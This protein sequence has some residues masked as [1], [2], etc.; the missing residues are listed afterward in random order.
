MTERSPEELIVRIYPGENGSFTLY[1]DDGIS[2]EY[3]NGAYLKTNLAYEE[4]NGVIRIRI[5]PSGK[6]YAGMPK[7]R[8][9]R[10]EL[11]LT[12]RTLSVSEDGEK[13]EISLENGMNIVQTEKMKTDRP[14]TLILK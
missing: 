6:G 9:Y 2:E 7:A 3:Q 11:P 1:E 8:S 4:Q 10:I 12:S 5:E 13:A 14:L